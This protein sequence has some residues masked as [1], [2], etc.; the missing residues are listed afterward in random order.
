VWDLALERDPEEE[1]QLA[2]EVG[3]KH[4]ALLPEDVPPQLLFVH[5][6]QM[7]VKDLHW[8]T[9]IPGMMA[10]TAADGFNVFRPSNL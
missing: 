4:N 9:Q 7:D 5:Q 1:A 10:T 8:H 3:G 6:G 2:G